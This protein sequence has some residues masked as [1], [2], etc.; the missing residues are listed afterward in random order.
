MPEQFNGLEVEVDREVCMGHGMCMVY[1]PGS[2][3]QDSATKAVF[4]DTGAD[5]EQSIRV[6][7]SSCPMGALTIAGED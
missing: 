2:F 3:T 6:A 7:V 4:E 1:A 5:T